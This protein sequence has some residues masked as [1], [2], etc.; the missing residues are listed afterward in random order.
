MRC[1]SHEFAV[2]SNAK[3]SS[4]DP[5]QFVYVNVGADGSAVPWVENG[6]G[7]AEDKSPRVGCNSA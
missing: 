5:G 6:K 1:H 2:I 4:L 7:D 3:L